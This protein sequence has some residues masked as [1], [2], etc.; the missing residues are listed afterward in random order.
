MDISGCQCLHFSLLMGLFDSDHLCSIELH[1]TNCICLYGGF[2]WNVKTLL[3]YILKLH[4]ILEGFGKR[5]NIWHINIL[6]RFPRCDYSMFTHSCTTCIV[7]RGTITKQKISEN[8][9]HLVW[10]TICGCKLLDSLLRGLGCY[11]WC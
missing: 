4:P 10:L 7:D 8:V 3:N 2:I 6:L 9:S 5:L 1:C 11:Y